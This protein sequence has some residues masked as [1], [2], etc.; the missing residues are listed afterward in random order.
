MTT[1]RLLN[2]ALMTRRPLRTGFILTA[3]A[4][5]IAALACGGGAPRRASGGT[6]GQ[7]AGPVVKGPLAESTVTAYRLD[8]AKEPGAPPSRRDTPARRGFPPRSPPANRA[9]P[10]GCLS[11]T[12]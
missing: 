9:V 6:A 12:Y 7:I 11:P 4:S 2:G 3:I 1:R 10:L 5:T 8:E